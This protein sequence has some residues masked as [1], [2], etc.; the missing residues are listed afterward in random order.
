[1]ESF[2]E[3][4]NISIIATNVHLA[5]KRAPLVGMDSVMEKLVLS[6]ILQMLA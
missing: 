6:G 1:M 3:A 2:A 4:S 5:Q